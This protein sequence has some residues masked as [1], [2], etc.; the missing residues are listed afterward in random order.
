MW[1][2]ITPRREKVN[3]ILRIIKHATDYN[4]IGKRVGKDR[5]G[6][7]KLLFPPRCIGCD[8]LLSVAD[9][10]RGYCAKCASQMVFIEGKTCSVCGK[11]LSVAT[12][13]RCSDCE[14]KERVFSEG[15]ALF[16][17]EGPM[18]LSMYRFKYSN[19][20]CYGKVYGRIAAVRYGHW[21]KKMGVDAI[22][23]VPMYPSKERMRGYNQAEVFAREIGKL[24]N[25]PV[26]SKLLIRTKNTKPQKMLGDAKRDENLKNAFKIGK[27]DVQFNCI[28]L[29]DDIYTTGS[30]MNGAARTLISSGAGKV[31]CL[32][33]CIGSD[34]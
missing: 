3:K 26:E 28:L 12:A 21:I 27:S 34:N 31:V 18:K 20:R 32:S 23:P 7:L 13:G 15:K 22:V 5:M 2:T 30:T 1:F 8:E 19:R 25:I 11:M 14:K 33:A 29:V 16:L 17:Y 4:K 10:K 9:V 24:L 6:F